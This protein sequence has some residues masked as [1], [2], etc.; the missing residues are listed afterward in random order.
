VEL[1]PTRTIT[2]KGEE[3]TQRDLDY[4]SSVIESVLEQIPLTAAR[5]L[6]IPQQQERECVH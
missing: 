3:E 1:D 6:G 5:A 4:V 2:S